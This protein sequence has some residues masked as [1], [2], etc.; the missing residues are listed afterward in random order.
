MHW[1]DDYLPHLPQPQLFAA[2]RV[3]NFYHVFVHKVHTVFKI[4]FI[5]NGTTGFGNC[6]R[7][8]GINPVIIFQR[9]PCRRRQ[10]F[11][12]E[13]GFL[14]PEIVAEIIACLFRLLY[15]HH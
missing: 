14:Y 2:L 13:P 7:L 3:N 5:G 1:G 10:H 12:G 4:A 11:A 15:Y 6:I 9:L 8:T